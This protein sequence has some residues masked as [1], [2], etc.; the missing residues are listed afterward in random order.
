MTLMWNK[1]EINYCAGLAVLDVKADF[2]V[3]CPGLVISAEEQK[4]LKNE[5]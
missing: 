2:T 3:H 4:P 5:T 1:L